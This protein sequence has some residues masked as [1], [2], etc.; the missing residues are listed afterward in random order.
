MATYTA[1]NDISALDAT[2]PAGSEDASKIDDALRET[3]LVLKT[4]VQKIHS[5]VG[6]LRA[7]VW[8]DITSG[9]AYPSQG[10]INLWNARLGWQ[11]V[12][13]PTSIDQSSSGS[14]FKPIAGV[15]LLYAQAPGYGIQRHQIRV[16]DVTITPTAVAGLYG[17]LAYA[18]ANVNSAGID[19][20]SV[21]TITG[22]LTT[23]GSRLFRV[24]HNYAKT[25][26]AGFGL[27]NPFGGENV[28]ANLALLKIG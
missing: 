1:S 2:N 16:A 6:E 5:N 25:N 22:I 14:V 18:T 12:S 20:E 17:T 27:S 24:E 8:H 11:K 15:Y 28:Y 7:A 3:R 13:D 26:T 19:V 21:S 9:A 23:D 4:V 10:A